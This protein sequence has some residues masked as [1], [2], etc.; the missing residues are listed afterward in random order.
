MV[1]RRAPN[2]TFVRTCMLLGISILLYQEYPS[3][4]RG[5]LG[6]L[7]RLAGLGAAAGETIEKVGSGPTGQA[8]SV[9]RF[10]G[11]DR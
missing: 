2:A 6:E 5:Y 4:G 1:L 3:T 9:P 11:L 7:H 8:E 10:Y